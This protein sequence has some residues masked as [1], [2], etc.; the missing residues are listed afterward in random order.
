MSV[1]KKSFGFTKEKEEVFAYEIANKKGMKATVLTYGAILQKLLV[2][3]ADGNVK[4][5]VLGFD[6]LAPY[7]RNRSFF[8]AT[9]GPNANRIANASFTLNGKKYSLKVNDGKNN[10]HSD[11]K[12]GYHKRVWD[13]EE[14]GSSVT[15]S[16]TDNATMGFP[17]K[18]EV[19]VTYEVTE[20]N[21]LKIS[22][23]V[24]ADKD[25]IINMTNHSY[26]NLLG[27][28]TGDITDHVLTLKA[29]RFTPVVRG[30]IPTGE[31]AD[32]A[33]TVFDFTS[34]RRIGEN[35]SDRIEQLKLVK[36]Y[37]HNWVLDNWD[38]TLKKAAEVTAPGT[39][40]KMEVYT[41][42][43]GIQFYAGNCITQ[44]PGKEGALY[45]KRDGL[46][47]ETQ[48]YPDTANR[49]EFPSAVFGP[50]KPYVSNTVYKFVN[51]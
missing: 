3:D 7:F 13:A 37:D 50:K 11:E 28:D 6:T 48:F 26:F 16:L 2:P 10:L 35:I 38:G 40:L 29:S 51:K 34:G 14:S 5:V 39:S 25:T 4:D 49:A 12:L 27:H 43:P 23:N 45:G 33:G 41:D 24:T 30:A 47:L 15:F 18:K 17:G 32:V 46:C 44:E 19:R 21:E 9:I 36:G 31:L 8:G 22:Y 42:L 20:K 1:T